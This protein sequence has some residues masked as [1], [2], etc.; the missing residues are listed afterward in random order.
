MIA[1]LMA[2]TRNPDRDQDI[3]KARDEGKTQK[4]LAAIFGLSQPRICQILGNGR[5]AQPKAE[6]PKG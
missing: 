5:R 2:K 3:R 6:A 1:Y 4:E